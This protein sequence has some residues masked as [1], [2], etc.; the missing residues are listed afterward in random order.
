MLVK[1]LKLS[2]KYPTQEK[3]LENTK[4]LLKIMNRTLENICYIPIIMFVISI[5]MIAVSKSFL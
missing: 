3:H 5:K 1:T 2:S 4:D